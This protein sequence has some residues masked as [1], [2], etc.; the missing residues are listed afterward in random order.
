MTPNNPP[1]DHFRHMA[2]VWGVMVYV[3]MITN[4]LT[5][6]ISAAFGFT[7][8]MMVSLSS[9]I[10]MVLYLFATFVVDKASVDKAQPEVNLISLK[11]WSR[12]AAGIGYCAILVSMGAS[13][14]LLVSIR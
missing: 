8:I 12:F 3:T 13:V 14:A 6:V 10:L 5:A 7:P 1:L 2:V 11:R 4:I 9:C